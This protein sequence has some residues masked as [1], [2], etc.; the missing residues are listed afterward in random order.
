M[1]MGS[2]DGSLRAGHPS[3]S[4]PTSGARSATSPSR[5]NRK[6]VSSTAIRM[7]PT[8]SPSSAGVD[9]RSY[10]HSQPTN[11]PESDPIPKFDIDPSVP[12]EE[13][14]LI[15][16]GGPTSEDS[17]SAAEGSAGGNGSN[18]KTAG[19]I[20]GALT[21]PLESTSTKNCASIVS[22][23]ELLNADPATQ[24][25]MQRKK[26]RIMLQSLR[27]KQAAEDARLRKEDDAR[28]R[29]EEE[30]KREE[31][32]ARRKEEEKAKR[33]AILEQHRLKKEMEKLAEEQ[34]RPRTGAKKTNVF[35]Q[36]SL[37]TVRVLQ[38]RMYSKLAF[39]V[40][41]SNA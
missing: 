18:S 23:D 32:R 8:R 2:D 19:L 1:N 5:G 36:S 40:S 16:G 21:I 28:M 34:V 31:E 29:R 6:F 25:E 17:E 9:W 4:S 7:S 30:S 11:D 33:D 35:G 12:L 26:E 14:A 10:D 37:I 3:S 15:G 13:M 38:Y 41:G 20:I 22:G 27:R 39:S 24:D